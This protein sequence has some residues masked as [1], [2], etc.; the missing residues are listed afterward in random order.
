MYKIIEKTANNG[1][2]LKLIR[3]NNNTFIARNFEL[4]NPNDL[5]R[6][7]TEAYNSQGYDSNGALIYV[8]VVLLFYAFSIVLM[9]G[10]S[11]KR[12][13]SEDRISRYGKDIEQVHRLER[14]QEKYKTRLAMIKNTK[15]RSRIP[16]VNFTI[17]ESVH[18][19]VEE[20][21]DQNEQE[22]DCFSQPTVCQVILNLLS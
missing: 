19:S 22:M 8:C 18:L 1:I 20:Y 15:S 9:I 16:A 11:M 21:Q 4:F 10:S 6:N 17:E 7:G 2:I 13:L 12:G 3:V 14:R 5:E